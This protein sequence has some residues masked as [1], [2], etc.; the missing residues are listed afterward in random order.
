MENNYRITK[1]L[2]VSIPVYLQKDA[3][4]AGAYVMGFLANKKVAGL[5]DKFFLDIRRKMSPL[6][7]HYGVEKDN[8][9]DNCY[10]LGGFDSWGHRSRLKEKIAKPQEGMKEFEEKNIP[11]AGE[12]HEMDLTEL[13]ERGR[14]NPAFMPGWCWNGDYRDNFDFEET[15]AQARG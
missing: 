10:I 6:P 7:G 8:S 3:E 1:M 14:R 9:L 13:I 15:D 2:G 11:E 4:R 12:G 5:N